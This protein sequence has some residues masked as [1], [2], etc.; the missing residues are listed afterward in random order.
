LQR[1]Q[2]QEG[3]VG[4]IIVAAIITVAILTVLLVGEFSAQPSQPR[5]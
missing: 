5:A 2:R 1:S 4:A 3:L